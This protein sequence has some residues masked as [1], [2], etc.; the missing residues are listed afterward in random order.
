MKKLK[1]ETIKLKDLTV[2]YH[3]LGYGNIAQFYNNDEANIYYSFVATKLSEKYPDLVAKKEIEDLLCDKGKILT[4]DSVIKK[5]FYDSERNIVAIKHYLN[6]V[7][8]T[9][10]HEIVHKISFLKGN[11]EIEK[12]PSV[13]KEAGTEKVTA[14]TLMSKKTIGY[15]FGN[16]WGKFPN[17]ISDYYLSYSFINQLN[18]IAG[19]NQIEKTILNGD[20]TFE[21]RLKEIYGEEQYQDIVSGLTK[22]EEDFCEYSVYNSINGKKKNET[23]KERL[24]ENIDALQD[25]I[26]RLSYDKKV[27]EVKN[28]EEADEILRNMLSFSENRLRR[29]VDGKLTDRAF[30]EYFLNVKKT[31]ESRF[32]G[33]KFDRHFDSDEWRKKYPEL[34]DVVQITEEEKRKIAKDGKNN[35]KQAKGSFFSK[36]FGKDDNDIELLAEPIK[37]RTYKQMENDF[38]K[39]LEFKGI[40]YKKK[41]ENKQSSSKSKGKEPHGEK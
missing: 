37:Q 1:N 5:G 25:K 28:H 8:T 33:H 39:S 2:L 11:G 18:H 14:E 9:L 3:K 34:V 12:I 24:S 4:I 22:I 30:E 7:T 36:L 19:K 41:S 6:R 10:F 27:S 20:L 16:V 26:L 40:D 15:V 17:T 13:I 38:N 23:L 31:L 35:Y 29:K 32:K 21:N